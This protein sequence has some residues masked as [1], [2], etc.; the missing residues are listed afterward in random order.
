M[1]KGKLL[2]ACV[3]LLLLAALLLSELGWWLIDNESTLDHVMEHYDIQGAP[4]LDGEYLESGR[5]EAGEYVLFRVTTGA[6]EEHILRVIVRYRR[7]LSQI[8]PEC[9]VLGIEV[10]HDWTPPERPTI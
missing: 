4:I 10:V 6:E 9:R 1:K 3:P 5:D 7:R 2:L 8:G